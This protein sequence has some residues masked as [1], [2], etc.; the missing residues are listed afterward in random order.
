MTVG[1]AMLVRDEADGI[2]ATLARIRPIV[3]AWTVID[4]G[5]EDGTQEL[6]R[7]SLAG[8]PGRLLERQWVNFGHNRSELLREAAGSADYLLMLDADHT[9]HIDGERPAHDADSYLVR[10]RSRDEWRLPLLTRACHPFE[11]RGV[12]HSFLAS[13]APTRT[14]PTDWVSIDGGPGAT[15]GKLERDRKLLEQAF[16]DNPEDART[17]FYLAQTYRDLDLHAQAIRFYLLR[18][19]MGGFAEEAYF[20]RYQAGVLLCEHV[21]FAQGAP[22]LLRAWQERPS[23]I[24]TLR[25]LANVAN[26]VA[27]KA[28]LP[29]DV[30]FVGRHAYKEA[31]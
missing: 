13:D 3:D 1:L 27:D 12:A 28:A 22:E 31:A 4:T 2:A 16:L 6:V 14:E 26:A 8:L 19:G 10:V 15:R 7:E 9:L 5:S 17:V 18:A 25:A 30:L 29:D 11:Y 21:A 20:A 23:R 24:E